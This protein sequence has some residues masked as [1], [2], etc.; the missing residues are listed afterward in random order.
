MKDEI[1][2]LLV[3]TLKKDETSVVLKSHLYL[4]QIIDK[5]IIKFAINPELILDDTFR[6]KVDF[7]YSIAIITKD[8]REK[9][10]FINNIRNKFSHDYDYKIFGKDLRKLEGLFGESSSTPDYLLSFPRARESILFVTSVSRI[11]QILSILIK[12]DNN[13]SRDIFMEGVDKVFKKKL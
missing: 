11:E 12:L 10:L 1:D 9:L 8:F 6:K 2:K 13:L 3:Y 7:L 4:E 5:M